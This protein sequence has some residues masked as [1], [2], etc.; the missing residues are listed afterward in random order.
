MTSWLL[1]FSLLGGCEDPPETARSLIART[2]ARVMYERARVAMEAQGISQ[3]VWGAT[4]FVSDS[5]TV[6]EQFQP[7]VSLVSE[8]IGIPMTVRAGNDYEH[9]ETMLLAG[10]I[11][12]AI[13]SPY[14]Y[15]Q[16]RAKEPGLRVFGSPI[17][18]GTETYG[19]YILTRDDSSVRTL[20]DLRGKPFAFVSSRST[21]GWLYPASRMLD[22][23][24]D[25]TK[26]IRGQFFGNHS[27]VIEAI[28]SGEVVAGA[29]YDSALVNGRGGIPGARELRVIA[30]TRRIPRDAYVVRAGFPV[31][32]L[33]GLSKALSSVSNRSPEGR[34]A[35]AP[36]VDINGFVRSEDAVYKPVREIE[37]TVQA[38]LGAGGGS[39]PLPIA[40]PEE[41]DSGFDDSDSE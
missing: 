2:P 32:A 36:L 38:L 31:E 14:A 22:E 40:Q 12:I 30:R 18:N 21:S 23:G 24:I 8:R 39:M 11:D 26:D 10:E 29:T 17:S 33:L 34:A 4:P 35:L 13:M 16:A 25:P 20:A 19:A 9:V 27:R 6:A 5:A 7:T 15:V 3:V 37:D 41:N 28:A 1:V